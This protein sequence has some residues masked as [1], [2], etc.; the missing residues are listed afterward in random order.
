MAVARP[1]LTVA[2]LDWM[3]ETFDA[4]KVPDDFVR[5]VREMKRAQQRAHDV[6]EWERRN[7]RAM[8]AALPTAP[9]VTG[10]P[11]VIPEESPHA[12]MRNPRA[13]AMKGWAF[14]N[15]E[16]EVNDAIIRFLEDGDVSRLPEDWRAKAEA[17]G[18]RLRELA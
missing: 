12:G 1:E 11:M 16:P 14:M 7:A 18:E 17:M 4:M 13:A 15:L 2:E 5:G 6:A 8:R 10:G 9:P 3:V